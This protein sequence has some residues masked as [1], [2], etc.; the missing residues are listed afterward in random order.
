MR[1]AAASAAGV[2]AYLACGVLT[3]H[4]PRRIPLGRRR[5][6]RPDAAAWLRQAGITLAPRQF[7]AVCAATAGAA[8]LAT[9]SLAGAAPVAVVPALAAGAAPWRWFARQR[10]RAG[11]ARAAAWPDALRQVV[12]ALEVPM[13]LHRALCELARSGPEPLREVWDRYRKLAGALDHAAALGAVRTELADPVG[14]RV[15]EVLLVAHAQGPRVVGDILR[16]LARSV[17]ADLRLAEDI[18]TAHLEKRIEA[19]S[20][21]VLPFVV[22]V[23]LCSGSAPYRDFYSSPA[24]VA[25]IALGAAMSAV[26]VGMIRRLGRLPVEP[27]VLG[28]PR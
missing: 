27:R 16:D 15:V 28:G 10:R 22:L 8:F 26:G 6:A 24:G 13:S 18:E 1:L 25:V 2:F 5:R 4:A 21:A 20:A 7:A 17:A 19:A 12:A 11:A 3:G 14:D 9:W 23:L